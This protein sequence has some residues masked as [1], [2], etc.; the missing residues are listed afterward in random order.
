VRLLSI[1]DTFNATTFGHAQAAAVGHAGRRLVFDAGGGREKPS[2]L[3]RAQNDRNPA[4]LTYQRQTPDQIVP[5]ERH[6]DLKRNRSATTVA[7]TTPRAHMGIRHVLLKQTK[8][9][10]GCGIGR[11]AEKSREVLDVSNVVLL[12]LLRQMTGPCLRSCAGATG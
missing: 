3:L 6:L 9:F 1:S 4:R 5:F 7:L 8:V 11:A 10:G 12:G 2:H